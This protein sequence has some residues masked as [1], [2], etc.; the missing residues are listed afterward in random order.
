MITWTGQYKK[1]QKV[2][3]IYDP[4]NPTDFTLETK[5]SPLAAKTVFALAGVILLV[6]GIYKLFAAK[7]GAA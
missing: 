1:G 7:G 3:V 5:Q 2:L 6:V 4:N